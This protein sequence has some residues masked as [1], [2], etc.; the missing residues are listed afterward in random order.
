M[1]MS[2][3]ERQSR[4]QA[5][6]HQI[7][8]TTDL[9]ELLDLDDQLDLLRNDVE[10]IW[11]T[12]TPS[13][14]RVQV[15]QHPDGTVKPVAK[16]SLSHPGDSAA[17]ERA[18]TTLR[19]ADLL[20]RH[21]KQAIKDLFHERLTRNRLTVLEKRTGLTD[22]DQAAR[23]VRGRIREELMRMQDHN[24]LPRHCKPERWAGRLAN[25]PEF[26]VSAAKIRQAVRQ[27]DLPWND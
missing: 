22:K 7:E 6:K 23:E 13:G 15:V 10:Q 24:S 2:E 27:E 12:R 5:L 16:V 25:T 19:K 17:G 3:N 21:L 20:A 4:I 9:A 18:L 11:H 8:A 26:P 14:Q 1:G